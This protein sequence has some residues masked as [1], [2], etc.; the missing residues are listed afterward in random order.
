MAAAGVRTAMQGSGGK[1]TDIVWDSLKHRF[2][3]QDGLAYL[4]YKMRPA[5]SPDAKQ[6]MDVVHTYVP[7]TKRGLGLAGELC[8]AAFTHAREQDVLVLPTCSYVSVCASIS[9]K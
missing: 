3:T 6:V 7:A 4:E 8:K 5:A 1:A 2:A 9:L